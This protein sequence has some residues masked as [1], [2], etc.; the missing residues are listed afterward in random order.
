MTMERRTLLASS[1]ALATAAT[2]SAA[3][4]AGETVDVKMDPWNQPPEVLK[5]RY[6]RLEKQDDEA[7][8][9]FTRGLAKVLGQDSQR[10]ESRDAMA[11]FL[12]SHGEGGNKPTTK[13]MEESFALMLKHPAYAARTRLIRTNFHIHW[14]N[15]RRAFYRDYDKYMAA[16]EA[17]DKAGPGSLELNPSLAI[18]EYA[19]YEIHTQPGGY[20]GDPFA[21]WIYDYGHYS[22]TDALMDMGRA[23]S[24]AQAIRKPDDGRVM[25]ILDIG[26]SMGH[27]TQAIKER[28][29]NAEVWGL[30]V[31]APLVRYAHYR[32]VKRGLDIKYVQR[33]AEDSKFPDGYF[34]IVADCIMFHEVTP[35][36]AKKIVAEVHRILRPGGVFHHADVAT[37]GQ[38]SYR[39][40]QSVTEKAGLFTNHRENIEPWWPMYQN[41]NFPDVIK[42]AGFKVVTDHATTTQ[43]PDRRGGF[44]PLAG[45]KQA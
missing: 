40:P 25:R 13:D 24:Y 20:V 18:P 32:A 11:A 30:D 28:F 43:G 21:G 39:A 17:T 22:G 8:Q 23:V 34:D 38:A 27:G 41:T 45:I 36:A 35:Q 31:G 26:C 44:P 2:A 42:A 9:H 3:H 37:E 5:K 33:L 1:A 7:R 29:P 10:K 4:A 19:K 14:D 16:M 6:Q 12:E 15:P